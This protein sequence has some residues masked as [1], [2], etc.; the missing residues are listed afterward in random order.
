[1]QGSYRDSLFADRPNVCPLWDIFLLR[2]FPSFNADP[3]MA[4]PPIVSGRDFKIRV[5]IHQARDLDTLE[6]LGFE[7][8]DGDI[9][10]RFLEGVIGGD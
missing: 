10:D 8:W 5:G 1:M 4:I 3:I 6:V 9:Q 2:S 7:V